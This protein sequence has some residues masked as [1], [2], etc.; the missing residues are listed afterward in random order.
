MSIPGTKPHPL[1][2]V[3]ARL[4]RA[5]GGAGDAED[6]LTK[7]RARLDRQLARLRRHETRLD[8]QRQQ[9]DAL[10]VDLRRVESDQRLAV[11]DLREQVVP[12]RRGDRLREVEYGRFM[13]QLGAAEERLGRLE[14]LASDPRL[15]E[16][17]PAET[18]EAVRLLDEVR[19]EHEQV[20][21]RMQIIS[22]YE[23]RLRRVEAAVIELYAGDHRHQV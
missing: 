13:L 4:A 20:R 7:I 6:P 9:L 10:R 5:R 14:Q 17:T 16:S 11:A 18:G 12:L 2:A 21:V 1:A 15:V 23:E 8:R 22:A 3:R 19:R